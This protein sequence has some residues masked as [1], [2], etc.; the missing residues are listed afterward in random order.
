MDELL[1]EIEATRR[2]ELLESLP[3]EHVLSKEDC[4]RMFRDNHPTSATLLGVYRWA[5]DLGQAWCNFDW[6]WDKDDLNVLNF[7]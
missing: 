6:D 5:A 4:L 3:F 1:A 7:D 2:Q